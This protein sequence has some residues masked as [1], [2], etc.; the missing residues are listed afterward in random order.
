MISKR[1]VSKCTSL[2]ACP[3][4]PKQEGSRQIQRHIKQTQTPAICQLCD[5]KSMILKSSTSSS[6]YSVHRTPLPISVFHCPFSHP[7][8]CRP[9]CSH[10]WAACTLS[11]PVFHSGECS[12]LFHS[13]SVMLLCSSH[14]SFAFNCIVL[15]TLRIRCKTYSIRPLGN[16]AYNI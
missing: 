2:Q 11:L 7:L 9:S 10:T 14:E 13:R 1:N 16:V 15:K 8:A 5:P 4:S 6:S 12:V 3:S